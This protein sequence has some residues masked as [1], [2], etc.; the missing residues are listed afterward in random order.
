MD[1]ISGFTDAHTVSS[2][3]WHTSQHVTLTLRDV[4]QVVSAGYTDDHMMIKAVATHLYPAVN[5]TAVGM[6]IPLKDVVVNRDTITS[7]HQ[8][9]RLPEVRGLII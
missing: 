5:V 4:H 7:S 9:K 8:W 2:I 1:F 3:I 6:D